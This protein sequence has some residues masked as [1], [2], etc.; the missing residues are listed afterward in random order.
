MAY[1]VGR[2]AGANDLLNNLKLILI[3]IGISLM[4]SVLIMLYLNMIEGNIQNNINSLG[5]TI[6]IINQTV[7]K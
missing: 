6:N 3:G 5:T 7:H 1:S 4:I 2:A